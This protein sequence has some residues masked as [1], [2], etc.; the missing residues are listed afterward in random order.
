MKRKWMALGAAGTLALGSA[1]VG[2][3]SARMPSQLVDART[4]YQRATRAPGA[5]MA[6]SDLFEA[7]QSLDAAEQA[8]ANEGGSNKTQNLAYIAHRKAIVAGAKAEALGAIEDKRVALAEF[9]RFKEMRDVAIRTQ[10]ERAKGALTIAQQ[11][12]EAQRQARVAAEAKTYDALS[13]IEGLKSA[14]SDRGLVLT[15]SG[16]VL[17]SA[18]KGQL[19][20]AAKKKLGEIATTLRDDTRNIVVLG[21]TDAKGAAEANMALSKVRADAVRE[22]LVSQG[23]EG[24]RV[25]SEGLG[26]TQ[27]VA[28]N[29]S[30]EG[31]A[32]NRRVEIILERKPET[33]PGRLV[34][35]PS[36]TGAPPTGTPPA[37]GRL[38]MGRSQ[39]SP[40]SKPA[41][42]PPS[43]K[44]PSSLQ[45]S[46]DAPPAPRSE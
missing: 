17:F 33:P 28:D 41:E 1:N 4:A 10:L 34:P 25:R 42:L 24:S 16:G 14:E 22:Y 39:E 37:D 38:P 27:P 21:H 23:V 9:Q 13:R 36:K 46:P 3:A 32:T 43:S 15:L 26:S 20:A 6:A 40:M 2:C 19:T 35:S 30:P 11:E 7:R 5:S 12:A 45:P 44:P 31:R 18:G 29:A 8:F